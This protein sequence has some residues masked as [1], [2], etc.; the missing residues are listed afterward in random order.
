MS[1]CYFAVYN[2]SATIVLKINLRCMYV[3]WFYKLAKYKE[4]TYGLIILD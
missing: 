1:D 4:G 3:Q 2:Y